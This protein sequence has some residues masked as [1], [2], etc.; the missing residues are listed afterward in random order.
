[1]CLMSSKRSRSSHYHV[2]LKD[3]AKITGNCKHPVHASASG[4]RYASYTHAFLTNTQ[5]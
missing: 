1:M 3:S 2:A 4:G 5:T